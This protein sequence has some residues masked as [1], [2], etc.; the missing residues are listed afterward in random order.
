MGLK[1]KE[2]LKYLKSILSLVLF[3]LSVG[4]YG[5]R[6]T[7][8]VDENDKPISKEIFNNKLN[9][10][11][12]SGLRFDAD[13]LILQKIEFKYNFGNITPSVKNQLFKL[14]N[15]R[16][17]IDT[18]KTLVIHY[19]DTLRAKSDFPKEN[20]TVYYD[21]LNNEIEKITKKTQVPGGVKIDFSNFY[22]VSKHVHIQNYS[23]FLRGQKTCVRSYK[24]Y[25]KTASVLHFYNIN[26]GHPNVLKKLRWYQDYGGLLKKL[27]FQDKKKF[28]TVII[29]P[30]GEFFIEYH[31]NYFTMCDLL[32]PEKWNTIKVDFEQKYKALNNTTI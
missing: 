32:N 7:I 12:Y 16:H 10:P 6:D 20:K 14:L 15:K 30:S 8:Y 25:D 18:T 5:Q 27:F 26:N 17:Q 11:I 9:S 3:V 28:Y 4:V 23:G 21:S 1:I 22:K 31:E 19:Q 2:S 13:T 29:K 24:K